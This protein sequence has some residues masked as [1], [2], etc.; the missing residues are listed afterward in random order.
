MLKPT[1]NK[2]MRVLSASGGCEL[3]NGGNSSIAVD[4][5]TK[6]PLQQRTK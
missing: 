2:Q 4:S 6:A 5:H 1:V 3:K